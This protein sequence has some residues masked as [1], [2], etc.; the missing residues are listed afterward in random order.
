MAKA[1]PE[2]VIPL[3]L[4]RAVATGKKRNDLFSEYIRFHYQVSGSI[5]P[6]CDAK[7]FYAAYDNYIVKEKQRAN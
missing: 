1:H 5:A 6:G 4:A 2:K 7:D 3:L